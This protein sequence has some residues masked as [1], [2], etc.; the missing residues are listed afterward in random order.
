MKSKRLGGKCLS[1]PHGDAGAGPLPSVMLPSLTCLLQGRGRECAG[2]AGWLLTG[3]TWKS[4]TSASTCISLAIISSGPYLSARG[5][6]DVA[7]SLRKTG[8]VFGEP[9]AS[10]ITRTTPLTLPWCR[11]Q[12]GLCQTIPSQ[13]HPQSHAILW[14]EM[15]QQPSVLLSPLIPHSQSITKYDCLHP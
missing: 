3:H 13:A 11:S 6:G 15:H 8:K 4:Y 12:P 14:S 1:P 2:S 9:L 5:L 10:L 7:G